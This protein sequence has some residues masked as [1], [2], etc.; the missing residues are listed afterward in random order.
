MKCIDDVI[1]YIVNTLCKGNVSEQEK[2]CLRDNLYKI[3]VQGFKECLFSEY[4]KYLQKISKSDT[5][6]L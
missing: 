3:Y 2:K 5:K 4:L 1:N 6:S